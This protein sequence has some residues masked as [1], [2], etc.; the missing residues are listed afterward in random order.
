[1]GKKKTRGKRGYPLAL[2]IGFLPM[3]LVY[4]NIFSER[5]E[6]RKKRKLPRKFDNMDKKQK[7]A[8]FEEIVSELRPILQNELK[9]VLL[10]T[11]PKK[12]EAQEFL[13]HLQQHH[14]W[15]LNPDHHNAATFSHLTGDV[16]DLENAS[17][18]LQSSEIQKKIGQANEIESNRIMKTLEQRLNDPDQGFTLHT[19]KEIEDLIYAGGTRKK[20][21][22]KLALNPEYI[23]ITDQYLENQSNKNRLHRLLQIAQNRQIRTRIIDSGTNAGSRLSNLGGIVCFLKMTSNYEKQKGEEFFDKKEEKASGKKT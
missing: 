11:K 10:V 3:H 12:K 4:Y 16:S 15:I 22:K 7:Y 14:R 20:K 18:F 6:L 2:L 8:F 1:M 13:N 21:F 23:L 19:L 5:V 9:N 17:I